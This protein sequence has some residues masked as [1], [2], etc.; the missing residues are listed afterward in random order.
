MKRMFFALGLVLC[1]LISSCSNPGGLPPVTATDRDQAL[2]ALSS[3]NQSISTIGS[4]TG[5]PFTYVGPNFSVYATFY[6]NFSGFMNAPSSSATIVETIT[7]YPDSGTA[8]TIS[9]TLTCIINCT[10]T[11]MNSMSMKGNFTLSGGNVRTMSVDVIVNLST[12][13]ASGSVT[14]NGQTWVL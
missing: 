7:N 3:A 11:A 1:I 2:S 6:P 4:A 10:N 14:V 5:S 12:F 8:Y 13:A 9:G